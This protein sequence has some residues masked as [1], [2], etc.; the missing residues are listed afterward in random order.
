LFSFS[1]SRVLL[2]LQQQQQQHQ[3]MMMHR[4]EAVTIFNPFSAVVFSN[5]KEI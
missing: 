5:F 2:L 1:L 4:R 3:T